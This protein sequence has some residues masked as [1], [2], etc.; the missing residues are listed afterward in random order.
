[1][2]SYESNKASSTVNK[3][4]KFIIPASLAMLTIIFVVSNLEINFYFKLAIFILGVLSYFVFFADYF[5]QKNEISSETE[6]TQKNLIFNEEVEA[7]LFALEEAHQFFGAS[8][9]YADMFRLVANRLNEIVPFATCTL[10]T[11]N[12]DKSI[13]SFEFAAGENKDEF[14]QLKIKRGSGLAGTILERGVAE[15][16]NDLS[17]D[18]KILPAKTLKNMQSGIGV[19]LFKDGEVFGVII[20]YGDKK[21]QFNQNSMQLLAA[22]AIRIAPL[23]ISSKTFESNLTNSLT[24]ALT[25]LPNERAFYLVLENQIAEA[26]RFRGERSLTVLTIDVKNFDEINRQYG[27]STGDRLLAFAADKINIELRQM[28]FL[29]RMNGDEFVAVFPTAS[30][31]IAEEI[32]ERIKRIFVLNAFRINEIENIHLQLNFG[33]AS[34]GQDG[35]TAESLIKHARIKKQQSKNVADNKVLFFPKEFV[36]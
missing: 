1:M 28:D 14:S 36:N 3:S 23:F 19:P 4:R 18:R 16:E 5:F 29:A 30:D 17:S 31:F 20:L 10:F 12:D 24:D 35:D 15:I 32:I 6:K 13:L 25:A 27:H 7:K 33:L 8:L 2:N 34:F 21:N 26:Q 11:V 9:K 22:A